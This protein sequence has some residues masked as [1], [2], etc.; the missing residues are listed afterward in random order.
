MQ[1]AVAPWEGRFGS[2]DATSR[3]FEA[4]P[5][6]K[7]QRAKWVGTPSM[8]S[9]V[10][11]LV[12]DLDI[13]FST[14]VTGVVKS[15]AYKW[16]LLYRRSGKG[17]EAATVTETED[18]YDIVIIS[19]KQFATDRSARLVVHLFRLFTANES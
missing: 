17:T 2:Y 9:L 12:K 15:S 13:K 11:E 16:R 19:D 14:R 1:G 5:P 10:K 18:E 3:Q 8:N 7:A 6:E 4:E